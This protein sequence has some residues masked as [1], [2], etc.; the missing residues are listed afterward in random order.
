MVSR[1]SNQSPKA[2][3]LRDSLL[4]PLSSVTERGAISLPQAQLGQPS[5]LYYDATVALWRCHWHC[6]SLQ[7]PFLAHPSTDQHWSSQSGGVA[8]TRM[9]NYSAALETSNS[10]SS[11]V[12]RMGGSRAVNRNC[13]GSRGEQRE[14]GFCS[15]ISLSL[16]LLSPLTATL[17][18]STNPC[19]TS[20]P[21]KC[22]GG[23]S[24]ATKAATRG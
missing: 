16:Q 13:G 8:E 9:L 21:R 14:G 19:V 6:C 20:S 23:S 5:P 4:P 22:L 12:A 17:A 15:C 10:S 24:Y 1:T 7:Y 18:L 2:A 3:G 11:T